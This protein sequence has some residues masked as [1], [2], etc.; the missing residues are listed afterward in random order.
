MPYGK[1]NTEKC[2]TSSISKDETRSLL[3]LFSFEAFVC[4]LEQQKENFKA[5]SRLQDKLEKVLTD[6][7]PGDVHLVQQEQIGINAKIESRNREISPLLEYWRN[8]SDTERHRYDA[9]RLKQII[10]DVESIAQK[11]SEGHNRIFKKADS[12]QS[13]SSQSLSESIQNKINLFR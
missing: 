11:V 4:H 5:L 8:M 3:D 6:A 12:V 7:K 13:Q 10:Q 1:T 9:S 2:L